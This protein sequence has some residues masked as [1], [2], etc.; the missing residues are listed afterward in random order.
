M[1]I[2]ERRFVVRF[3]LLMTRSG[4]DRLCRWGGLM[5]LI[6]IV[7]IA[8]SS[9]VGSP[10]ILAFGSL[11]ALGA[12]GAS[13]QSRNW[14]TE[15]GFWMLAV[16]FLGVFGPCWVMAILASYLPSLRGTRPDPRLL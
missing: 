13:F 7:G 1:S 4:I 10:L 14:R 11:A 15:R 2:C 5:L 16:L 12:C 9:R 3:G 8:A 6:G